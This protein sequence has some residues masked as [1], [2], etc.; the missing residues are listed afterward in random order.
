MQSE[1]Y[2]PHYTDLH[3]VYVKF[4]AECIHSFLGIQPRSK[5]LFIYLFIFLSTWLDTAVAVCSQ[6]PANLFQVSESGTRRIGNVQDK[7]YL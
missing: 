3:W 2:Y 6:I 5:N 7:D 4:K 1:Y